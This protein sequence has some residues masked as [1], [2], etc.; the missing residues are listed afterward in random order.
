MTSRGYIR[1][2]DEDHPKSWYGTVHEH[3]VVMEAY[4]GRPLPPGTEVHHRNE[5][6]KDNRI[7]NLLL[8]RSKKDHWALHRAMEAGNEKLV[9][10]F[11]N[12]SRDFMEKLKSGLPLEDCFKADPSS[13]PKAQSKKAK[14]IIRRAATNR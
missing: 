8:M 4:I 6:R 14:T 2:H 11:E 5:D 9:L 13:I 12:W 1:V 3:V 10:G 7:E